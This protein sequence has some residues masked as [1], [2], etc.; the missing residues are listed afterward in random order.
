MC[1]QEPTSAE[2]RDFFEN[3][4]RPL[5]AQR[6]YECHSSTTQL[7]GELALDT[8][9]GWQVGGVSGTA[10][11][12]GD[13]QSSLLIQAISYK[14]P[15]LKMP[16]EDAG[17]PLSS[18]QIAD[19]EK[20]ILAGAID[21]RQ[22]PSTA[23]VKKSWDQLFTER[24][25]WWSLQPLVHATAPQTNVAAWNQNDVDRFV[26]S[27]LEREGIEPADLAD[28]STLIR[29]L[30]LVLTGL[31]PTPNELARFLQ[32]YN[33]EPEQAYSQLVDRLLNSPAFGERFARHWMDVVRFTETHGN[34]WN[35]DVPYAWRYRDYLIRA[36]N[37]DIPYDQWLREHIAGDLVEQP[38]RRS[39]NGQNE[40]I[41]GTAFYRFG[42]VNH[43]SCVLF[44]V[45]GYD[46]V[47]NQLDTLTKAFQATTVAC[48]RCH[49]HKLDAV[50]TQ[51]Y[52]GLLGILRST[53]SVQHNL[54]P[55]D[56]HAQPLRQLHDLKVTIR[57]LLIEHWARSVV[58]VDTNALDA[59]CRGFT[60]TKPE[61]QNPL[62]AWWMLSQ[63]PEP[64]SIETPFADRWQVLS[65]QFSSNQQTNQEFNQQN[66]QT[67]ADFR[68]GTTDGWFANGIG[69]RYLADEASAVKSNNSSDL[70]IAPEG[71]SIV[72]RI[73]PA[74]I[75][76]GALS[77]KLNGALRSPSL[78]RTHNKV[79]FEV[80]GSGFSLARLVFNNCQ[81]NYTNQHSIHHPDWSWITVDFQ[82]GTEPLSPY[83]ELLTYW[84]NPKFPDP[85]GT[86]SKDIEN[87]R[88]P[89]SE[90]SK[91]PRTWWGVR[92]VVTHDSSEPPKDEWHY[93]DRLWQGE[94]PSNREELLERYRKIFQD[95]VLAFQAGSASEDDV[96]WLNWMLSNGQLPHQLGLSDSLQAAIEQYRHIENEEIPLPTMVAGM[97]DETEGFSQPI[98]LRGDH[99][100]PGELATR[101]FLRVLNDSLSNPVNE[102][103]S[104]GKQEVVG[105]GRRMVAEAIADP[106]NPLTS[107][108]MVN[109]IWQWIFGFG[110][111]RTPD[112]FG[113]LGE[114]P[115]HPEL[116]DNLAQQFIDNQWSIKSLI[117]SMVMSRTFRGSSIATRNMRERDPDNRLL[118]HYPARRAEAEAIR[119][120]LLYASGRLDRTM[121]GPSIHPYRATADNE[122]RLYVGPLDGDGRRSIYLKNQLMEARHFIS[123]FNVPGGKVTQGRRDRT[124]VPAQSLALLNDPLVVELA[125][126]WSNNLIHDG[127]TTIEERLDR[128]ATGALSRPWH[129]DERSQWVEFVRQ[130]AK[131]LQCLEA[132]IMND[133]RVWQEIAHTMFNLKEMIY[134]P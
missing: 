77:T 50:S 127:A 86:L 58:A 107:R 10:I 93:L 129:D 96:R 4:I 69:L 124:N 108:V 66:F 1:A 99:Q 116:L 46:I 90:H 40:S 21:P 37:Q 8:Q 45:I 115:S 76:S 94:Q 59:M 82:A 14:D 89:F 12:P 60:E 88:L 63:P 70:M 22:Q 52:Y 7:E 29:R 103:S 49:D 36:F 51:D 9:A 54:D 24:S 34:E 33:T 120:I 85:L 74:G 48:A 72:D 67:L 62:Y 68:S 47:D 95:A 131:Q 13:P 44:S 18:S 122:K 80:I 25:Q 56:S 15:N 104:H 35:Y 11:R 87:Q 119:D 75:Y 28:A 17:G 27:A 100:R 31:P 6:C 20:W 110:I 43:D 109:R 130:T 132:N 105:S 19:L 65:D 30:T 102:H 55:S 133:Q 73:L 117:R 113:H 39:D 121:Y 2:D 101:D 41:I 81:L 38:R 32:E 16:P 123:A 106:R 98:F 26:Y 78:T 57:N 111:V 118:A 114:A 84:D 42:E 53:R 64:S 128:M 3:R 61:P 23:A 112:D 125:K 83:A 91:N 79:S 5:L 71:D 134:I 126:L 97:S 92:R